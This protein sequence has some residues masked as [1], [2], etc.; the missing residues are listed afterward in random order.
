MEAQGTDWWS[1]SIEQASPSLFVQLCHQ[2]ATFWL[3]HHTPVTHEDDVSLVAWRL[4]TRWQD[5]FADIALLMGWGDVSPMPWTLLGWD[6]I[7]VRASWYAIA[8][9]KATVFG[10]VDWVE[11][12][13]LTLA[14]QAQF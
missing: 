11:Q 3:S 12:A 5:V 10:W 7:T 13:R 8:T 6:S 9:Y 14:E 1:G 4:S 2:V